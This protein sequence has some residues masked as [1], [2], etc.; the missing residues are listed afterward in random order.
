MVDTFFLFLGYLVGRWMHV[1]LNMWTGNGNW[2]PH[3][4]IIGVL[5]ILGGYIYKRTKWGNWVMLLG[6]GFFISDF[7]DFYHLRTFQPDA[8]GAKKFW[9]VD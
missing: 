7:N 4:W 9:G 8:G 6:I 1:Y 5:M 2:F 3:H